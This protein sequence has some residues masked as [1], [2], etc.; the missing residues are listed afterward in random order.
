MNNIMGHESYGSHG[1]TKFDKARH[2]EQLYRIVSKCD[3]FSVCVCVTLRA[4][5]NMM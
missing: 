5:D 4:V 3:R 2:P 1:I